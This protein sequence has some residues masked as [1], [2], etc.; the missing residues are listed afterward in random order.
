MLDNPCNTV[1]R[2]F[3]AL[4]ALVVVVACLPVSAQQKAATH[5]LVSVELKADSLM[6]NDGMRTI[7]LLG[8]GKAKLGTFYSVRLFD[9]LASLPELRSVDRRQLLIVCES[10]D[11]HTCTASF[12]EIDTSLVKLPPLLLLGASSGKSQL[13]SFALGDSDGGKVDISMLE[14]QFG[15]VTR[16]RY[17]LNDI[18]FDKGEQKVFLSSSMRLLF[19]YD[20]SVFRWLTDVRYIHVLAVQ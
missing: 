11:G 5:H 10:S 9:V 16:L 14:K 3:F 17:T 13:D 12:A 19:P 7:E 20:R 8:P 18:R 6:R 1:K 2:L 15:A 4:I